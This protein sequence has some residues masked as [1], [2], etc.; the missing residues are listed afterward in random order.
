M[1]ETN[2]R[3]VQ[4]D[5]DDEGSAVAAETPPGPDGLP[6]LGKTMS[7]FRGGLDWG[8]E[9]R[10]EYGDVVAFD[11]LGREFVA[12]YDPELVE[13]VLV[14]R[15]DEFRKGEFET[16]AGDAIAPGGLVF[17]EGELWRRDRRLLQPA[18][19]PDRIRSFADVMVD[20]TAGAVDRWD[21]GATVDLGAVC[22]RLTLD[23]LTRTLLDVELDG[24]DGDVVREAADAI[25][26]RASAGT[27]A[28]PDWLPTPNKRRYRRARS[29]LDD[30]LVEL[31]AERRADGAGDHDDLLATLLDAEYPDGSLMDEQRLRDQL[32]TFLFAGHETTSLALTFALW[33]VAGDDEVRRGLDDE[34]ERVLGDADPTFADLP[35]L[36]LTDAVVS[37]ALR[38]YPPVYLLYRQP[39]A[40][41]TLGGYAVPEEATL[42]LGTY[43]VHHDPR[44]WDDPEAF[45]PSRWLDDD[46]DRPE[47]AYF[48]FGGGPRH[49]IGMRFAR[50]ELRLALAT[51]LQRC[52]FER[53][54]DELDV[55]PGATLDV[56][57]VE[58]R[59]E[60]R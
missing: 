2:Q 37:E 35:E 45:R 23:V 39:V 59:V 24:A 5:G 52:R 53:V 46:A 16:A 44:W 17:T 26:D 36:E 51:I 12:V 38:L 25:T 1:G 43:A 4:S 13:E 33:L 6:L 34:F 11:A 60:K 31:V 28:T 41:T 30:L 15:N 27:L 57:T 29:E 40:D 8:T 22:P 18:F 19:T 21:D 7:F 42:L 50:M 56:G 10:D 55:E 54:S 3:H 32:V 48:P 14:A 49:C 47:Y 20:T 58:L 9:L